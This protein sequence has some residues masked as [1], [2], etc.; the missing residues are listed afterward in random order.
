MR[1]CENLMCS[2]ALPQALGA[3]TSYSRTKTGG[4]YWSKIPRGTIETR[5]FESTITYH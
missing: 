4:L 5:I 3:R 2:M 1:S